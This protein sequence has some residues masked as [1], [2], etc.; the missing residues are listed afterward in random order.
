MD[1]PGSLLQDQLVGAPHYN[2][3]RLAGVGN[4]CHL[5]VN[6]TLKLTSLSEA[7]LDNDRGFRQLMPSRIIVIV[8]VSSFGAV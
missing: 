8:I 6:T 5:Q 7:Q 3:H 2:G 4:P 1:G